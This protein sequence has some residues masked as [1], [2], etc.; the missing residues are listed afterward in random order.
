MP[1]FLGDEFEKPRAGRVRYAQLESFPDFIAADSHREIGQRLRAVT[2]WLPKFRISHRDHGVSRVPPL[3]WL[4]MVPLKQPAACPLCQGMALALFHHT[5]GRG[6]WR[7]AACRLTFVPAAQHLAAADARAHYATHDNDP[8]DPGYRAFLDRLAKWL[9]PRLTP[10]AVGLDY[11]AGPGPTL[12]MMLTE[13]GFP[14]HVY[15]PF[16]AP[17]AGVL[18]DTYDFVTCTETVEH[19]A[20]PRAE[21]ERF[22]QLLR[23]GGWLGVMTQMQE[24]DAAFAGWWYTKDPTHVAFYRADTLRWIAGWQGWDLALPAPN[25]ALFQKP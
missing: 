13:R 10:G 17:D 18:D 12:S 21:F 9:V 24:D 20:D 11:G 6:F 4:P 23:P 14:T 22:N 7:C 25:I 19:F 16:F 8:A 15:D 5:P 2:V 1:R 3:D